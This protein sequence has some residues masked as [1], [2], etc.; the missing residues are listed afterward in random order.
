VLVI[1]NRRG[2]E[3]LMNSQ[4]KIGGSAEAAAGPIGR[5]AG[6]ST[7]AAMHAEILSY[8]RSRGL[9][10]G[11]SLNGA[12]VSE[13]MNANE[14]FYGS[15]LH[16]REIAFEGRGRTGPQLVSDWRTT[17]NRYFSEAAA[18]SGKK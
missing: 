15:R 5:H 7:D 11:I 1:M 9:F 2:I 16:T 12:A 8:S 4:F 3:S 6:A 13:D 18:T 10:A 14:S 17:L